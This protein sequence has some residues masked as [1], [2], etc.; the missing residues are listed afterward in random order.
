MRV[1]KGMLISSL[2]LT[3]FTGIGN[4]FLT[5]T[6]HA[7]NDDSTKIQVRSNKNL[8][9]TAIG[10]KFPLLSVNPYDEP[11]FSRQGYLEEAPLGINAPYAWGIKGGDGQGATFVDLEE[12]WLLNHEDLVS[13]NIEFM[14]VKILN[15]CLGKW[16]MTF[17]TVLQF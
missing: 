6:A 16:V 14:S 10:S 7:A 4:T 11:R 15:L 12:G 5:N 17:L 8:N 2:A 3:T 9:E 1:F 13:Q